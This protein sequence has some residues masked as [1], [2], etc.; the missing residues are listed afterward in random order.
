MT[1]RFTSAPGNSRRKGGVSGHQSGAS[2]SERD[3]TEPLSGIMRSLAESF[4]SA[5]Q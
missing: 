3:P 2:V 5:H 1:M 4:C